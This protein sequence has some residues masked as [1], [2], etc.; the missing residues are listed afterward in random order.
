MTFKH[1]FSKSIVV[2]GLGC[3]STYAVAN[4]LLIINNTHQDSTSRIIK[5]KSQKCTDSMK[6]GK[7]ITH[8]GTQNPVSE[9]NIRV[10]CYPDI[11]NCL[12]YVYM[13]DHC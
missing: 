10:A 2:F 1:I 9:S 7:G 6:D 8:A 11:E 13:N 5:K 3:L 12:A 4:E